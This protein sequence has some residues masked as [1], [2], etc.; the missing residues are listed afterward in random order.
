[1]TFQALHFYYF[2][3][4]LTNIQNRSSTNGTRKNT[5]RATTSGSMNRTAL[6]FTCLQSHINLLVYIINLEWRKR[7][8]SIVDLLWGNLFIEHLQLF[9][10]AGLLIFCWPSK[11]WL[12]Q[13]SLPYTD[14]SCEKENGDDLV[15]RHAMHDDISCWKPFLEG[16][17]EFTWHCWVLHF[18]QWNFVC[19][20]ICT[21]FFLELSL[22]IGCW[23]VKMFL[24]LEVCLVYIPFSLQLSSCVALRQITLRLV[25]QVVVCMNIRCKVT[26]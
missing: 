22:P 1:M 18:I 16:R 24:L 12:S 13:S 3:I 26:W 14:F 10:M 2:T 21:F 4:T 6:H 5:V 15:S 23:K 8:Y 25:D 17:V 7:I 9:F 19:H 11:V 20:K